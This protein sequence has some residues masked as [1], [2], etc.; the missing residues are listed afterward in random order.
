MKTM[1]QRFWEKVDVVEDGCWLWLA[2]VRKD[3]YGT[4]MRDGR[5]R[6]G[7]KPEYAHRV[8]YELLVGPIPEGLILDH[9]VARGCKSRSCVNPAHL[10]PVTN[11]ENGRR[12]VK[13][14]LT[15]HCPRGH[16]YDAE[17]TYVAAN[18]WRDCRTCNREDQ[19]ERRAA[20]YPKET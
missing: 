10:E 7:R 18:G 11:L 17:N 16:E 8:A 14:E 3:G 6:P 20:H 12:G 2:H 4:F 13:G 1:E 19:R 9:V 5:R 15:T